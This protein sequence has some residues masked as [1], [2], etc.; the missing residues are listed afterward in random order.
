M[1]LEVLKCSLFLGFGPTACSAVC[2]DDKIV[3]I[4]A[5]FLQFTIKLDKLHAQ[6][7]IVLYMYDRIYNNLVYAPL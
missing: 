2:F 5:F 3:E 7:A 6:N 4:N 1:E